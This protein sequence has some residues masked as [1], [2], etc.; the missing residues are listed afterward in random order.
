MHHIATYFSL[1]P[2]LGSV[3]F[4]HLQETSLWCWRDEIQS[5]FLCVQWLKYIPQDGVMDEIKACCYLM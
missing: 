5:V 2:S 4:Y 3:L 1:I